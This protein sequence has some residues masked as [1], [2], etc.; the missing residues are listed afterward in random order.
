M[1]GQ[2]EE[3]TT[4]VSLIAAIVLMV[5]YC[6]GNWCFTSLMDGMG[7]M[8]DIY[9]SMAV[10]LKPY[11]SFGLILML[12]SHVLS[13]EEGFLYTTLNTILIIWVLALLIFGM[14]MTH[15]Y[16]LGEGMK[17]VVLTIIGIALI[18]FLALMFNQQ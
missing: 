10:S 7:T 13:L 12:L 5:C 4:L 8:K 9:I 3:Q 16:M 6:V 18:I 2:P 1:E 17:S 15:D 11:V 14:L